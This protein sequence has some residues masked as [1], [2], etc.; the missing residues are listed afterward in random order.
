MD[1]AKAAIALALKSPSHRLPPTKLNKMKGTLVSPKNAH[2]VYQVVSH[3]RVSIFRRR[4]VFNSLKT[5]LTNFTDMPSKRVVPCIFVA[6]C[7]YSNVLIGR[8]VIIIMCVSNDSHTQ[9]SSGS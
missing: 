6:E 4:A 9:S 2:L 8:Y 7:A 5:N 3:E 1:E